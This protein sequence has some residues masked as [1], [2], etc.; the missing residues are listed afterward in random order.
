[1]NFGSQFQ[2]AGEFVFANLDAF[3]NYS[4]TTY[5]RPIQQGGGIPTSDFNV[6]E[7]SLYAQDE[8]QVTRRLNVTLGLRYDLQSFRE[9]PTP[10]V[11]VE[12]AFGWQTGFAP[13]DKN[14]FSPRLMLAY[15]LSGNGR[16][17]VRAGAGYFYGVLP[18]VVAGN[19]LQTELPLQE[20]ICTGS[21]L[22][23]DP[24]APPS[25][26]GYSGWGQD[27]A[28]NPITCSSQGAGGIP[29]YTLWKPDFQ[30][31]E[32]FKANLGFEKILG[33]NTRFS[34]DLIYS[35]SWNLYTVRNLNLRDEQFALAGEG[36]R[37][38]FSPEG[39]FDPT[40]ANLSGA[41]RNLEFGDVLVNFNDGR[42]QSMIATFDLSHNFSRAFQV[43]LSYTWTNAYDNSP[44]SCC[45][46]SGGYVDP[47]TGVYGPNEIGDFGATDRAWGRS[48]F[49]RQHA[50]VATAFL[51]LPWDM[52]VSAFWKSQSGRPWA[53]VGDDDL[54]GD[55]ITGNDR[56]F[57][58][59]PGSLPL[60]PSLSVD[61]AAEQRQAYTDL[62]AEYPCVGD[63]VGT[64]VDRNTCTYP[65]TH[66]LDI[67][68]TQRINTFGGQRAEIQFDLF[69][70][71][72]GLGQLF[73]TED[74]DGDGIIDADLTKGV[75]GWGRVTGV[76]GSN[77]ELLDPRGYDAAADQIYY[78]VNSNFG[79][80][81]L[82]GANL[83]LQFQAQL[84]FRYYF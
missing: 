5:F 56:T 50:I 66:Q 53:V 64:I 43:G 48:D 71:L 73:C 58:Y 84:S 3:E 36:G 83:V 10:V 7:W 45:T 52:T 24:D 32:T 76:F 20:V 41:R 63:F 82:L 77:Q 51:R 19:V 28:D 33:D 4:A 22:D 1:M 81:E 72:N 49:S 27:G 57:V 79:S 65:W 59:A 34:L 61:A 54:N 70:V 13:T 6:V 17:V 9:S 23:N 26:Q 44:Y 11:D 16:T 67:R 74:S 46:A 2:G 18:N 55:G 42:A 78:R 80:E 8:W 47:T 37:K 38:V 68:F 39:L 12:R 21:V 14:N 25:P 60:D 75:C 40:S 62:L 29:T 69:N 31:P 30:Y 15:D 35:R